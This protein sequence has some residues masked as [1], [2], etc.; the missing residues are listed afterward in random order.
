MPI[1]I[2]FS[3]AS[4]V[5]STT[6]REKW[7]MTMMKLMVMCMKAMLVTLVIQTEMTDL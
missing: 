7:M 6:T 4:I 1:T 3:V 5:M 2:P